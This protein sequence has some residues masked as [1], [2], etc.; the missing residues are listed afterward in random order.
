[1][2]THPREIVD[3]QLRAYNARDLEAYCALF[4]C[5]AV[6]S[7]LNDGEEIARGMDAIRAYYTARFKGPGLH[8]RIKARI[9]LEPFVIDHEQVTGI[10]GGL[11]EVV[12]IYEVRDALIQS[13]R[14]IWP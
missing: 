3:R 7:R 8:C 14:I 2:T 11:L 12:A 10:T 13:L 6:I 9:E 5:D 4:A 1:M